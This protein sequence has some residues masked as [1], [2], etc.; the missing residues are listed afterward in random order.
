MP[1]PLISIITVCY[2]AEKT[3]ERTIQS[4]L[5]QTYLKI[6]YI[7]IDGKSTDGTMRIVDKYRD[8]IS[9]VISEPDQGY[10]D[11]LNKGIRAAKGE[12]IH[13]INADD[14]YSNT[15]SLQGAL[16]CADPDKLNYYKMRL[17]EVDGL[18]GDFYREYSHW[19]MWYS[20]S[21]PHPAMLLSKKQYAKIGEYNTGYEIAGDVEFIF[22]ALKFY[23]PLPHSGSFVTMVQGGMSAANNIVGFKEFRRSSIE[24]GLHPFLAWG[25]YYIKRVRSLVFG[26]HRKY[27]Q[28]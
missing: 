17:V 24:H 27:H 13:Q 9:V 12:W 1:S 16:L 6:E 22:R 7:I 15:E 8:R 10:Y 2:N 5:A 11:A 14:Y 20:S 28:K 19:R 4:V 26:L 18:E 21:I 25:F 3:I 23:E